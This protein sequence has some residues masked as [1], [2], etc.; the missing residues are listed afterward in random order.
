MRELKEICVCR[1]DRIGD[2]IMTTPILR[3]L[4]KNWPNSKITLIVSNINA[5]VLLHSNLID[6]LIIVENKYNF[7]EKI[8]NLKKIRK[9]NFDLYINFSPTKISYLLC[10]FSNAK[11]KSTMIYLSRYNKRYSKIF[12]RFLSNIFCHYTHIVDRKLLYKK[13]SDMHQ[14]IMMFK[15][16]EKITKKKFFYPKLKITIKSPIENKINQF[17]KRKIITIHL[18]HR[19]L[20]QYYNINDLKKLIF[21]LK[22]N[23]KYIYFFTTEKLKDKIFL[24]ATKALN[25]LIVNDFLDKKTITNKTKKN[26]AFLLDYFQYGEWASVIKQSYKIISPDC[27]CVHISAAFSKHITVIY[28]KDNDLN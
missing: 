9:K 19:W 27:G 3:A 7:F 28:N 13:N 16:L 5:K 12:N 24:K 11:I 6:N 17:L 18:S 4:R 25:K 2:L 22:K 26:N 8:I 14:T 20:N 1:I 23:K 10:Y 21:N 15:L